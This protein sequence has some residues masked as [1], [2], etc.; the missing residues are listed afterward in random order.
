MPSA[1]WWVLQHEQ[2]VG[3]C[4][5]FLHGLRAVPYHDGDHAR[6]QRART[7]DH[8]GDDGASRQPMQHL[9]QRRMHPLAETGGEDDDVEV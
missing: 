5:R 6:R 9:R 7:V 8:V 2:D 1:Q 4:H 3:C